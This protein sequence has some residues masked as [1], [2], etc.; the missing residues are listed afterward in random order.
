MQGNLYNFY[1]LYLISLNKFFLPLAIHIFHCRPMFRIPNIQRSW[2]FQLFSVSRTI[3]SP[4]FRTQM[5]HINKQP[6]S[7]FMNKATVFS[8]I[9]APVPIWL[10][11]FNPFIPK[12]PFLYL[13][14][15]SENLTV[16]WWLQ[17]VEKRCIGNKWVKLRRFI[18]RWRLKEGGTYFEVRRVIS[19]KFQFF[20]IVSF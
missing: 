6:V 5:D 12:A 13:L 11:S 19:K 16:F 18:E 8:P 17:G 9:S 10:Y 20:V 3:F 14:K 1:A 7:L 4:L 2:L 15:T